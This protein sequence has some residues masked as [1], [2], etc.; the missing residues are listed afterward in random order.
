MLLLSPQSRLLEKSNMD[1]ELVRRRISTH[2]KLGINFSISVV[3]INKRSLS[4]VVL[5]DLNVCSI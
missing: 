4:P 1:L 3:R 5:S 2:Y